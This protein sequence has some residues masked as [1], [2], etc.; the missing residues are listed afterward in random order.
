MK[1]FGFGLLLFLLAMSILNAQSID[2][3][4]YEEFTSEDLIW[5]GE[6]TPRDTVKKVKMLISFNNSRGTVYTFMST[7]EK[8]YEYY[9]VSKRWDLTK[10]QKYW[11]YFT[12]KAPAY[13]GN[14]DY[15]IID[16][17]DIGPIAPV[18][19]WIPFISN[20]KS[21]LHG[22]YLQDMGN[23]TYIEVYFE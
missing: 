19:P 7:D 22:W 2:R 8:D 17:I 3:S 15:R 12:T 1:K 4:I 9:R 14:S 20:G 23:G 21:G 6:T 18:K 16:D 13:S 10:G 5:W 11:V